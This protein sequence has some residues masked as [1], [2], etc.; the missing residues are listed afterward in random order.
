MDLKITY[1]AHVNGKRVTHFYVSTTV[2]LY[3]RGIGYQAQDTQTIHRVYIVNFGDFMG[4]MDTK[5]CAEYLWLN[6]TVFIH[7]GVEEGGFVFLVHVLL[8]VNFSIWRKN[9]WYNGTSPKLT[10]NAVTVC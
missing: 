7:I 10:D 4:F 6:W 8:S 5:K 2:E 3:D 1:S 9:T